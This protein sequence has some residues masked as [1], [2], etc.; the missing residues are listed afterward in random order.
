MQ[1]LTA[2]NKTTFDEAQRKIQ[3]LL[4]SD[5]YLRFI[6]SDIY[7][8]L[9]RSEQERKK[10][11]EE[12]E[13]LDS[14]ERRTPTPSSSHTSHKAPR[15]GKHRPISSNSNLA[16]TSFPEDECWMLFL[17]ETFFPVEHLNLISGQWNCCCMLLATNRLWY[18]S[19]SPSPSVTCSLIANLYIFLVFFWADNCTRTVKQSVHHNP[20]LYG[21]I[22]VAPIDPTTSG[23]RKWL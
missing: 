6:A 12:E 21:T 9:L 22:F 2:P 8:E 20:V 11:E 5:S 7:T 3:S 16:A 13:K 18:F 17:K 15:M 1:A 14:D 10:D 19:L 4:E 23:S